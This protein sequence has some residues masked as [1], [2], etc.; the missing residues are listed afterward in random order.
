MTRFD[1]QPC[2]EPVEKCWTEQ[3]TSRTL[4]VERERRKKERKKEIRKERK[5]NTERRKERKTERKRERKRER[6]KDR[7][8][9]RKT[10]RKKE[11]KVGPT[12]CV[13]ILQGRTNVFTTFINNCSGVNLVEGRLCNTNH[14]PKELLQCSTCGAG[15]PFLFFGDW[16]GYAG[17]LFR[18][19]Y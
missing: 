13:P 6:K 18:T 17:A 8:K 5:R 7:N 10:E 12:G 19:P 2:I 15:Q 1:S 9:E 16:Y 4:L 11:R 3:T 14:M